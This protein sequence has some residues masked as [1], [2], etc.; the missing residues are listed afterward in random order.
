M[1]LRIRK[2]FI[3]I[4]FHSCRGNP[5]EPVQP[6]AMDGLIALAHDHI[7][8]KEPLYFEATS[9]AKDGLWTCSKCLRLALLGQTNLRS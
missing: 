1:L 8:K 5:P 2:Y 9:S 4:L 6:V 7:A 3:L